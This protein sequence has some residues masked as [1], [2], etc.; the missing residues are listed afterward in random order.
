MNFLEAIECAHRLRPYIKSR[1]PLNGW[2]AM[3]QTVKHLSLKDF[4]HRPVDSY[5]WNTQKKVV[6]EMVNDYKQHKIQYLTNSD[7]I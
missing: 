1:V 3:T 5:D 7:Y 6:A 4:T 2:W